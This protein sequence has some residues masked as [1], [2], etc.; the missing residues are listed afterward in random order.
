[1]RKVIAMLASGVIL[2]SLAVGPLSG[3]AQAANPIVAWQQA[4]SYVAQAGDGRYYAHWECDV[5]GT[6]VAA[7][8]FWVWLTPPSAVAGALAGASFT[9]GCHVARPDVAIYMSGVPYEVSNACFYVYPHGNRSQRFTR[10]I[11]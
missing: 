1:M 10:C 7:G 5:A 2:A 4:P 8:I 6:V 9:A 3:V 11:L